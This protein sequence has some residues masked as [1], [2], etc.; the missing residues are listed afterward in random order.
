MSEWTSEDLTRIGNAEEVQVTSRRGD[1]TLRKP[2]TIWVVRDG[3]SLYVRSVKGPTGAWFRGTQERHEGR[4]RGGGADQDI[5][6]VDADHDIGDKV[7]AAYRAKYRRYAGSILN[8]VLTPQARS[9]TI[10]LVPR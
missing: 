3:D 8:S 4:I 2:V 7:D 10:Q 1:G 5:T 9:T 6:F